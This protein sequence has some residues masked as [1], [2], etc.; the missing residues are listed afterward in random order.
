MAD[1]HHVYQVHYT[2]PATGNVAQHNVNVPDEI[3][4]KH[5]FDE[6]G[7][8]KNTAIMVT[9]IS[10]VMSIAKDA[11]KGLTYVGKALR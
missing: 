7:G 6:N 9:L 8:I 1:Y 3:H 10:G 5:G 4:Q 2:H 11:I